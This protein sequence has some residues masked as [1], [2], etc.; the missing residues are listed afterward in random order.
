MK[1]HHK[2]GTGDCLDTRGQYMLA[3]CIHEETKMEITRRAFQQHYSI[4]I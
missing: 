4:L 3:G 2:A 1:D